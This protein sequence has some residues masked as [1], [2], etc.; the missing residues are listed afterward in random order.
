MIRVL[1]IEDEIIIARYIQ[2]LLAGNFDWEVKISVSVEE[3]CVEMREFHPQLVLCD[4]NLK[5]KID[6]I[7]LI[8]GF[9][10]NF[11]F[12]TIFISSYQSEAM[13][14]KASLIRPAN[15]ILKPLDEVQFLATLKMTGSRLTLD[16]AAPKEASPTKELLTKSEYE[17]LQLI[18]GNYSTQDIAGALH[19]S[20]LTVKNHRH[21]ICRKLNLPPGNN[22]ILRWAMENRAQL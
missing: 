16:G 18:A 17:V 12:E 8:A 5:N 4:I 6:G 14:Q 11:L 13:I 20:P 22:S 10:K 2:Q 15:Y 9:Q 1:I 3:A 21:N 19:I 7:D